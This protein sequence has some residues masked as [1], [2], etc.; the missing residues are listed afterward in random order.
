MNTYIKN[1]YLV[2]QKQDHL[3]LLWHKKKKKIIFVSILQ[4]SGSINRIF[5]RLTILTCKPEINTKGSKVE[6]G[7]Q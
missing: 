7:T 6:K 2:E 4:S 3:A 1:L 5:F